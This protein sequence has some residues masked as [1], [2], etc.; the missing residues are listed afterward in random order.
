MLQ[1]IHKNPGLCLILWYDVRNGKEKWD[2]AH[3]TLEAC[4]G[5][6]H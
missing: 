2:A 5:Q 6:S 4:M 1:T 3:E